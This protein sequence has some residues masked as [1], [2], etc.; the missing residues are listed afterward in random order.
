MNNEIK[1]EQNW[2]KAEI[3]EIESKT[4][5]G[6]KLPS[7]IFEE[8]KVIEFEVDFSKPFEQWIDKEDNKIKK[9]IPVVQKGERKNL[10]L[11]IKNPLYLEIIKKGNVGHNQFKVM[12]IGNKSSTK[13]VMVD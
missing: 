6:E 12:Q 8:N 1:T 10:W 9:I 4:L 3:N 11:N 2:M 5:F 13:Y 7:L